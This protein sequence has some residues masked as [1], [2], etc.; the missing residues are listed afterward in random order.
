MQ[1]EWFNTR[2]HRSILY[3]VDPNL[4]NTHTSLNRAA[5]TLF[6]Q[7]LLGV[8][9][10]RS[11]LHRIGRLDSPACTCGHSMGDVRHILLNCPIYDH[12][13]AIFRTLRALL[14]SRSF[15]IEEFLGPW[16]N[17]TLQSRVLVA[18]YDCVLDAGM[19]TTY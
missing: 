1:E 2:S 8:T 14:D 5:D 10:T 7:L 12:Y 9:F 6:H 16:H 18:F 15:T 11:F 3:A 17:P 13:R 4:L 19:L